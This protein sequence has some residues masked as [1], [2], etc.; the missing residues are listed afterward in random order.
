MSEELSHACIDPLDVLCNVLHS[1]STT[2]ELSDNEI[3]QLLPPTFTNTDSSFGITVVNSNK[4]IAKNVDKEV[5]DKLNELIKQANQLRKSDYIVACD[6]ANPYSRLR[7]SYQFSF[8]SY[9]AIVL[10]NIQAVY[11]IL[12]LSDSNP[13][14]PIRNNLNFVCVNDGPGAW[15]DYVKWCVP[16]SQGV[17]ISKDPWAFKC[18]PQG[19]DIYKGQMGRSKGDIVTEWEN[20]TE[21]VMNKDYQI[22]LF[23]LS[24]LSNNVSLNTQDP[25]SYE[26][27]NTNL[28][29]ACAYTCLMSSRSMQLADVD[30]QPLSLEEIDAGEREDDKQE[31]SVGAMAVFRLPSTYTQVIEDIIYLISYCYEWVTLFK[32]CTQEPTDP[33]LYLICWNYTSRDKGTQVALILKDILLQKENKSIKSILLGPNDKLAKW[34]SYVNS[35]F[36]RMQIFSLAYATQQLQYQFDKDLARLLLMMELPGT[37]TYK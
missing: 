2:N 32:P 4:V 16:M 31:I 27:A 28:L 20:F 14:V 26:Q 25:I 10:A 15:V 19:F 1:T 11:S 21:Y 8:V 12:G 18:V 13:I 30:T 34:L 33:D 7:T 29:I 17:G 24:N 36:A 3:N 23:L 22:D 9:H 5:F 35:A 37:L 6:A